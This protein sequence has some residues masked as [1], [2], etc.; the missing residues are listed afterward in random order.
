MAV[1]TC[2]VRFGQLLAVFV[3]AF[4]VG[5][6]ASPSDETV[7]FIL[8]F[9][10]VFGSIVGAIFLLGLGGLFQST[11][12]AWL[13]SIVVGGLAYPGHFLARS[14]VAASWP[15]VSK[16][17]V[18]VSPELALPIYE[19]AIIGAYWL[20]LPFVAGRAFRRRGR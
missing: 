1:A 2:P 14:F 8:G 4:I 13:V 12:S 18:A 6:L 11:S 7:E 19:T 5:V 9:S 20:V 10:L 15:V 16:P 3:V 17:L